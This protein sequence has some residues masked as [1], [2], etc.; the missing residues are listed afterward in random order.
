VRV[1]EQARCGISVQLFRHPRIRIRVVA[2][3]PELLLQK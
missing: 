2:E 3:R 1:A